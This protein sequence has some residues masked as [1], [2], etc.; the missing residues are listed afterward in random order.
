LT[1]QEKQE[2][3]ERIRRDSHGESNPHVSDLAFIAL[4]ANGSALEVLSKLLFLIG[5]QEA[6]E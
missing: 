5:R 4:F 2:L 1:S 6:N 3:L